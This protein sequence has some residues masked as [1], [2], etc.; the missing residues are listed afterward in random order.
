MY[1]L[2]H[3]IYILLRNNGPL[4][5]T[6][7]YIYIY[8]HTYIYTLWT[9]VHAQSHLTLC[10]PIG[11]SSTRLLC[12]W[13]F[14][15]KNTGVGYHFLSQGIFLTQ[16]SNLRLCVSYISRWI[17]YHC[18]TWETLYL[19][20]CHLSTYTYVCVCLCVC[21]YTHISH[22]ESVFKLF[23]LDFFQVHHS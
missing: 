3:V 23:I 7:I 5:T 1:T 12:P 17:I 2:Q 10:D 21:V 13:D 15:G 16:G 22:L 11:C 20:I 6:Y 19:S 9:C 14:P 4:E 18:T 8:T